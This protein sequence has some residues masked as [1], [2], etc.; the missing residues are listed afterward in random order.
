MLDVRNRELAKVTQA[1]DFIVSNRL[2]SLAMSQ[3]AENPGLRAVFDDL[4]DEE[5]SEV[6]LKPAGDYVDPGQSDRLLHDRRVGPAAGRG[7]DR[8]PIAGLVENRQQLRRG[9]EPRQ[10]DRD[11]SSAPTD[12]IIVLAEN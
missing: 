11:R 2:V 3:L 8:L 6:Y 9:D 10:V 12:K 1:D 5:G 7:R 4:F